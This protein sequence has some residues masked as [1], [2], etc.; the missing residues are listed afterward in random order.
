ME[1][2]EKKA[3]FAEIGTAGLKGTA[4]FMREEFLAELRGARGMKVYREMRD[5]SD[6]VGSC[7]GIVDLLIQQVDWRVEPASPA[8]L[9]VEIAEFVSTCLHDMSAPW[10]VVLGEHLTM[11][12]FGWAFSEIVYKRRG[13]DV[14]A[15]ASRS[16]YS[17]GRIGWRKIALRAQDTLLKWELDPEGGIRGMWQLHPESGRGAVMIP[18]EKALLMRAR[19]ECNNPEGRSV[20][21]N[22]YLPWYFLKRMIEV[23]GIAVERDCNGLPVF[24]I[25]A[26]CMA[27]DAPS[28]LKAAREAAESIVK[29][30]RMDQ[31]M[32]IVLPQSY[33]QHG[34]AQFKIELLSTGGRRQHDTSAIIQR[35]G[36][37]IAKTIL[38]DLV[39]MGQPNTIQYKGTSIPNLFATA[40][41]GWCGVITDVY[42]AFA[43]PR[44]VR[45]NG[46]PAASS[47]R[48]CH[49][50]IEATD[51]GKLGDFVS[52]AFGA[53]FDWSADPAV[54]EHLRRVGGMPKRS[55]GAAVPPA[56]PAAEPEEPPNE[57][58]L[59]E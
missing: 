39:L 49:G 54:D 35:Y 36:A 23:E 33:D 42:N 16:K 25:P 34:N 43:I 52:K 12:P 2:A 14:P 38:Y 32:G 10:S 56:P 50:D 48:L 17:D 21:R 31:E 47:P 29:N 45:L 46:W 13:G 11:L 5:N 30:I 57:D 19:Q 6:D 51:L 55:P 15:A 4:G 7:L 40:L 3:T 22:A 37:K 53:G 28:E 41:A 27:P 1:Q 8:A 9:D 24:T 58:E 20:L 59:D 26:A 18:I 44:L